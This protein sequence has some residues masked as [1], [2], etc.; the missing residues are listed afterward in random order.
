MNADV[1]PRFLTQE[2]V[3]AIHAIQVLNFGGTGELRDLGLLFS[4]GRIPADAKD[5]F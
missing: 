4:S 5:K 2:E 3:F 1:G